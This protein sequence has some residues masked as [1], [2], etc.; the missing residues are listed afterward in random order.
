MKTGEPSRGFTAARTSQQTEDVAR[1]PDENCMNKTANRPLFIGL[2]YKLL[3]F[4][5]RL[6]IKRLFND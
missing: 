2:S 5:Y 4:G 6:V 3:L 1:V